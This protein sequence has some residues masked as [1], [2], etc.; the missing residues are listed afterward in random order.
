ME[1]SCFGTVSTLFGTVWHLFGTVWYRLALN[2]GI[3]DTENT[4]IWDT[5]NTGIWDTAIWDPGTRLYGTLDTAIWDPGHGYTY[6]LGPGN[7]NGCPGS[8]PP[9]HTP[10]TPLPCTPCTYMAGYALT[11]RP[12][13]LAL[14]VKTG[15]SGSPIYHRAEKRAKRVQRRAHTWSPACQNVPTFLIEH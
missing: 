9:C 13:R 11:G 15:I 3:W 6:G 4:G 12:Q 8:T 7:T 2:T 5:E 10:G 1:F 14:S